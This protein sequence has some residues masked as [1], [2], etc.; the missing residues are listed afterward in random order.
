[1]Q[2]TLASGGG[3][4]IQQ[5]SF[6]GVRR[7]I[8][9]ADL[10]FI[11]KIMINNS[12]HC[13]G[14]LVA[15]RL[16][17]TSGNCFTN[18]TKASQL[19]V[20]I[21]GGRTLEAASLHQSIYPE[22]SFISLKSSATGI[23]PIGI[24]QQPL[25]MGSYVNMM[26]AS[27]FLSYYGRRRSQLISNRAC[28]S[29]Y[30]Q[31]ESVYI[32]PNMLCLTNSLKPSKCATIRGDSLLMKNS[33]DLVLIV[34]KAAI[35]DSAI[36]PIRLCDGSLK[37]L[38]NVTM[39]MSRKR[40]SF[41]RTQVIANGACKRSYAQDENVYITAN[42]LCVQNTAKLKDCQTAKGDLLLHKD[43][44]CGINIYGSHCV[45]GA[46]NGDLYANIFKARGYLQRMIKQ[47][48]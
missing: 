32:T 5:T 3:D 15:L 37:P 47:F 1:M 40:L 9:P 29:T 44:L 35:H 22:I 42:M 33:Q 25:K 12:I 26:M 10:A 48:V 45:N 19:K 4:D 28:K 23:K 14:A 27:P 16:V 13:S 36:Q 38:E 7:S 43:H 20:W 24:C 8:P 6:K 41:L 21:S 46:S 2:E 31:D 30:L 17:I 34:L 11:V 18:Q 39:Y